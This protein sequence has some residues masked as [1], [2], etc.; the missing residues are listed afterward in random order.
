M[1]AIIISLILIASYASF[2]GVS[3][4]SKPG[5][6]P[7]GIIS[8]NNDTVFA[9]IKFES[10][11]SLQ[12][13]V[14]FIDAGGK[15]KSF[16]PDMIQGFFIKINNKELFFESRDDIKVSVFSPKRG[17]FI[18]RISNDIY[19]LYYYITTRME[20]TGVESRMVEEPNYLVRMDYRWYKYNNSNFEDCIEIFEQDRNLVKDI[21]KGKYSFIEFPEIVSRYCNTIK[22]KE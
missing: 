12:G 4:K 1:K 19:P 3:Q 16:K 7:G 22:T 17:S 20:N 2:E 5:Y 11:V 9:D 18:N 15:R 14:K 21:E 10:I 6:Y 8:L 13:R